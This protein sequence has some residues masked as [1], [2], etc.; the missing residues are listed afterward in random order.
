MV[1]LGGIIPTENM[2]A[3][4]RLT[5]KFRCYNKPDSDEAVVQAEGRAAR[6]RWVLRDKDKVGPE[7]FE[8]YRARKEKE[9]DDTLPLREGNKVDFSY[10]PVTQ[11]LSNKFI[12]MPSLATP[13]QEIQI[14]ADKL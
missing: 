4:F 10:V 7:S 9:E 3:F 13:E 1:A 12:H 2:K 11:L 5:L 8:H 14:Q 6:Q